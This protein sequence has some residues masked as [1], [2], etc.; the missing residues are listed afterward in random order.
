MD[1]NTRSVSSQIHTFLITLQLLILGL[2]LST[3]NFR[4]SFYMVLEMVSNFLIQNF[5]KQYFYVKTVQYLLVW[6]MTLHYKGLLNVHFILL[7]NLVI[8]IKLLQIRNSKVNVITLLLNSVQLYLCGIRGFT[9]WIACVTHAL[10]VLLYHTLF[11]EMDTALYSTIFDIVL[12]SVADCTVQLD[13]NCIILFASKGFLGYSQ[14]DLLRKSLWD[15]IEDSNEEAM[16]RI[17]K[18]FTTKNL[19]K[20]KWEIGEKSFHARAVAVMKNDTVDSVLLSLTE[21]IGSVKKLEASVK[22]KNLFI[23]SISHELRNPLQ[24]ITYSLQLLSFTN[25]T[26]VSTKKSENS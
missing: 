12:E 5:L 21:T 13:R 19:Q 24:S 22:S 6:F 8:V 18:A 4:A 2:A 20:W 10:V 7:W 14:K 23:S 17:A 15:I 11:S 1:D 25:L 9:Y 26:T 16:Q 3:N